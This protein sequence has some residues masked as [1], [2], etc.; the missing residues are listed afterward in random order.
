MLDKIKIL[1][2]KR[3]IKPQPHRL[4]APND[5]TSNIASR[6]PRGNEAAWSKC[7][8]SSVRERKDCVLQRIL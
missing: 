1:H 2:N 4:P 7:L 3:T 8:P 5:V 6:A